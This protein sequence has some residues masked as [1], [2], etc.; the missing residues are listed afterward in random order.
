MI[1]YYMIIGVFIGISLSLSSCVQTESSTGGSPESRITRPVVPSTSEI[2]QD[3]EAMSILGAPLY[4]QNF[5]GSSLRKKERDLNAA[6]QNY[7]SNPDSLDHII[8]YGRRLAYLSRYKDAIN[9]YSEGLSKHPNSYELLRH[10]GH[11]YITTRQFDQAISD[12]EKAAFLIRGTEMEIEEDGIPNSV[13]MPLTSVQFNVW[14]HLGLAYYL[15]GNYDKAVSSYKKCMEVSNNDDLLVATSDWLY[16]TY[17][18]IGNVAAATALLEPI[19]S[20]MKIIENGAYHK[21]LLMYKGEIEPEDLLN[22][23]VTDEAS[24]L[25]M[26]T[27]GYGVGY[28]YMIKGDINRAR[29]IFQRVLETSY[30]PAFGYIASEVEMNNLLLVSL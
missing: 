3:Y 13:N 15:K 11:R 20:R 19:T 16:M 24:E 14:Y 18:K 9:I 2:E 28:H 23:R 6:K 21:R 25:Q 12:L 30:W 4:R 5:A 7:D 1:K 10:R 8:W 22:V 27:Q 29:E 26:A 17:R